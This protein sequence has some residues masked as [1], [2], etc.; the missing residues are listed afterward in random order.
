MCLG[1]FQ[2]ESHLYDSRQRAEVIKNTILTLLNTQKFP[3]Y[4]YIDVVTQYKLN[5]SEKETNAEELTV[6]WC[7]ETLKSN[8]WEKT[9]HIKYMVQFI[10]KSKQKHS[11]S[12]LVKFLIC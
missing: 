5:E 9:S 7:V 10:E 3:W 8:S 6:A 11:E 2:E 4:H 12:K 1:L